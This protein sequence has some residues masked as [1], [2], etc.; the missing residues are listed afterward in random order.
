MHICSIRIRA[1][2]KDKN[3][4]TYVDNFLLILL[5]LI[6]TT[7]WVEVVVIGGNWGP[8]LVLHDILV[9]GISVTDDHTVVVVL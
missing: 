1:N 5:G 6:L 9:G 3:R 2:L 7:D 8:V 4:K